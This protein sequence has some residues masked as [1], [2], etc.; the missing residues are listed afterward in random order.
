MIQSAWILFLKPPQCTL[1]LLDFITAV[2][3]PPQLTT[4]VKSESW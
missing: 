4:A 3:P 1:R 2:I